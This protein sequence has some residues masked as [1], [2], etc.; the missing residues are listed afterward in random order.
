MRPTSFSQNW[1]FQTCQRQWYNQYILKIPVVSDFTYANA[2]ST[3]HKIIQKYYEGETDITKLKMDFNILWESYKLHQGILKMKVDAYWLMVLEAINLNKKFTSMEFKIFYP[4]VVAYLDGINTDEECSEIADWKSSTRSQENEEQYTKQLKFYSWLFYRKFNRLPK[5]ATVYYL[6][7]VG[8]KGE[9]SFTP[10]MTDIIEMEDWHNGIRDEMEKIIASGKIPNRIN[11]CATNFFCPFPNICTENEKVLKY[12]LHIEGNYIRLEGPMTEMLNKGLDK[13]FSYE[14]KNAFFMKK[15]NPRARTEIHFWNFN[16]R[17]LPIGFKEGLVKTLT[18]FAEHKGKEIGIDLKDYRTETENN[19]EMPEKFINGRELRD[20]QQEAVDK[21]MRKRIAMLEIG[22]GGGKTEIAIE[23]I[24]RLGCKTLFVVDKVE[25]LRQTKKR[26][27]DSLGI[28]VGVIGAGEDN[29]KDI[30]VATIQTLAKRA[31]EYIKYL[32]EVQFCIFDETHKVAAKSYWKLSLLLPNTRYRLGISGTAFRDDG[33][34]MLINAV[35]GDICYNLGSKTLIDA[36]WLVQPNIIFIKDY[37][38]EEQVKLLETTTKQGLINETPNY[39]NY[40]KAF[41][42]ENTIRN[43]IILDLMNQ[44]KGSKILILTKLIDHGKALKELTGGEH[45]Y[46]ATP[47][48]ERKKLMERFTSGDL[49][50]LVSTISIF[51]EGIDIPA[52]DVIINA[53]ANKGDVK[54]IQMLGRC[55]RTLEGKKEAKYYDFVDETKFFRL[56][57]YA[58]KRALLKEGHKINI[59]KRESL[60]NQQV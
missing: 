3:I 11:D 46:G 51:S 13:K 8:S 19:V 12:I 22:T 53:G 41:I 59:L 33:N 1:M 26:I 38:K 16:K 56:A 14:L 57:S 4:D 60:Q 47:K 42:S 6:K 37:M 52:L 21:F 28:E 15:A 32:S 7:Y 58:R 27:E 54:T 44:P 48:E 35:V 9:L 5:K 34:D 39:N 18:D 30:T 43:N 49:N 17:K 31:G 10:T 24:R 20:Y 55:L 25:L 23:C 45:L 2:G 29:I 40:Y 50:I 36:G